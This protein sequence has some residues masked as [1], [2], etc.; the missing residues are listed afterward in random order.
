MP[1]PVLG[2]APVGFA[3]NDCGCVIVG[4]VELSE[5]EPDDDVD[6]VPVEVS[7]PVAAEPV[8]GKV[9][10]AAVAPVVF[11]TAEVPDGFCCGTP[12]PA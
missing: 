7:V 6:P 12:T 10:G 1:A 2:G 11:G 5:A 4:S 9:L 8:D 3:L